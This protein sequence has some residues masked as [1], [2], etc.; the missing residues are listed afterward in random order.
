MNK[1]IF[2][3]FPVPREIRDYLGLIS[4]EIASGTAPDEIVRWV[5]PE[6]MHMTAQFLG[7]LDEEGVRL[8]S[9]ICRETA[10]EY[11]STVVKLGQ[12]SWFPED[13]SPRVVTVSVSEDASL[14]LRQIQA[15]LGRELER[16]GIDVD[17]RPWSPHITLGRVK[18]KLEAGKVRAEVDPMEFTVDEIQLLESQR[19]NDGATY[20]PIEVF[21]LQKPL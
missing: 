7:D 12:P 19:T 16:K 9:E 18:T 15:A 13:G 2:I 21:K 17:H 10:G 5:D 14:V 1:R 3:A 4:R 11:R 20:S 6:G 8:A